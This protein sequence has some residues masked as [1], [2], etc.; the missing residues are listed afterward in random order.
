[1]PE[2]FRALA[3][4]MILASIVFAIARR[5]ACVLA[6]SP[7]D[8]TRRRNLWMALTLVA[9][10]AHSFWVYIAIAAILL[11]LTRPREPNAIALFF[12]LLFLI[13]PVSA[14]ITG[15]GVIN[16]FF[17]LNHARLLALVILFPAAAALVRAPDS[18]RFGSTVPDKLLL[19]YLILY[20]F[21]QMG[22]DSFTNSLRGAFYSFIDIILPYFVASRSLNDIRK[23]RDAIMAFV[24]AAMLLS[25][26]A[27]V[28]F[29]WHW[30]LYSSLPEVLGVQNVLGGYLVRNDDL[31]A[32]VTAGQ[33]IPLGYVIAVALGMYG[34]LRKS[35]ADPTL[36][37]LGFA[38]LI[39]GLI[40]P[41][42]RGPWIGVA[43]I[44]LV[45]IATGPRA[46]GRLLQLGAVALVS[47]PVL[48]ATPAGQGIVDY[49]PFVGSVDEGN[50]TYRQ[51]LLNVSIEIIKENPLFGSYDFLLYLEQLRQGQG[52]IDI[53]NTYLGV[54]LPTGLVGLTLF[55]SFFLTIA[56]G[57]Y[58]AMRQYA[59]K[60]GEL[61]LLGRSL[62]ATL[63]GILVIIFTV[64]SISYIAV[65]YW[66]VAGLGAA[67]THILLKEA[68]AAKLW[69]SQL[70][71]VRADRLHGGAASGPDPGPT[72]PSKNIS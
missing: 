46:V 37:W 62:L 21:L 67:C 56:V 17:S 34:F 44:F 25:A 47:V 40:A 26:L 18:P 1:M 30:L 43:V 42:S 16:H 13:P 29:V 8:F 63:I 24:L 36:W 2:H 5:P 15:L 39:A 64:S 54:L 72:M 61:H 11:F 14:E 49:L 69:P 57:L 66:S 27:V 59:D 33:P 12:L 60:D 35:I 7:S 48:L 53:V 45:L 10:L 23:F 3:V 55:L 28:E 71:T 9:F 50:V 19:G 70:R 58:K 22:A 20:F 51:L 38:L 6:M 65:V 31:R 52:I 68:A 32:Q 41:L 4:V